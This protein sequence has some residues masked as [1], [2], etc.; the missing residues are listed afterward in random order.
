VAGAENRLGQGRS[1]G[2]P[3]F[4]QFG[5]RAGAG[6]PGSGRGESR[7]SGELFSVDRPIDLVGNIRTLVQQER[8][9]RGEQFNAAWWLRQEMRYMMHATI[10]QNDQQEKGLFLDDLH[11]AWGLVAW[12]ELADYRDTVYGETRTYVSVMQ[13]FG[14]LREKKMQLSPLGVTLLDAM[15]A[16]I[17]IEHT[18][19]Q[20]TFDLSLF[21]STEAMARI[22]RGQVPVG[23]MYPVPTSDE[24][25]RA[26]TT[27]VPDV[28]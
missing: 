6:R 13:S 28:K 21:S 17:G 27:V 12:D 20:N 15:A 14:R 7:G 10:G 2:Q 4:Q 24:V 9:K 22:R 26:I 3:A 18:P 1:F 5:E 11:I 16:A 25:K 23:Y 19:G 8:A